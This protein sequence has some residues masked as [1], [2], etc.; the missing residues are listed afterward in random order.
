MYWE[1][2]YGKT[3]S[4]SQSASTPSANGF[5]GKGINDFYEFALSFYDVPV[6]QIVF[7]HFGI[8]MYSC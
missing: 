1:D 8:A 6:F 4:H 3:L 7:D 5:I 2:S